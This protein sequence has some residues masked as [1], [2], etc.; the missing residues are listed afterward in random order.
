ME[1]L[2][3]SRYGRLGASSRV[4][5][6]QYLPFLKG[7]GI[8]VTVSTLLEDVYV[9]DLFDGR[10]KKWVPIS[11]TYLR[12]MLQLVTSGRFDLL[13]IEYELF[14]WL[15]AWAEVLLNCLNVP[16]VVDYDDAVFH[17]YDMDRRIWVRSLLGKKI[18]KVMRSA[19]LV[20]AGNDYL[21]NRAWQ[22]GARQVAR[23]PT[24]IDLERY[25]LAPRRAAG[26]FTIGWI[27]SPVTAHYLNPL[28]PAL[29][30]F[31][32]EA[33]ARLVL[34]GSG[35]LRW[36][37]VPIEIRDWSED[38]EVS[39]IHE[40]DVGIM[41]L[42]KD[43]W[44]LGKCGY[45][46]IQYMAC[47]RP[48]VACPVGV[49]QQII[50]EGVNGYIATSTEEWIRVLSILRNNPEQREALGRAGREIV[51][52]KYCLQVTAPCLLSILKKAS[53]KERRGD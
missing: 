27:G 8:N 4:R 37:D 48:A 2:L 17:R 30:R 25:T 53:L 12:R 36:D 45:K 42:P 39:A 10:P 31:C 43:S 32:A 5:S 23:L 1:V 38:T 47:G 52:A 35:P 19:T 18:D 22:A 7:E 51:E 44:A 11:R 50:K 15:P 21:A 9:R 41:P 33:G 28:R 14:P 24:V 49:N 20:I 3:L 13:W 29:S 6:Y 16:F 46:L 40:F 26:A 34:V